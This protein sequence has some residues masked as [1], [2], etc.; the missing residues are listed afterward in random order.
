MR[1]NVTYLFDPLC[2]WCYG[3]SPV[4]GK[5]AQHPDI[6][7]ELAPTGLFADSGQRMDA[8]FAEFAWA[9]DQR[10]ASL[11][12]QRFTE[13]YR[14]NV[15][16]RHGM[17]FDSSAMTRAL[18]AVAQTEPVRELEVLQRLQQA[19]YVEGMDT[20]TAQV[21]D[22]LLRQMG[23]NGIADQV[24][25]NDLALLERNASRLQQ[26]RRLMRSLGAQGV[27]RLVVH[28]DSGMRLLGGNAL[29]G[30]FDQLMELIAVS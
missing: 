24:A 11:S 30:D 3:A 22:V 26:A 17:P 21:V 27:P 20:G 15:L 2:G 23:L 12:G 14:Q 8:S 13:A 5:L 1:T 6:Q 4:I 7:L 25:E 19:R 18:T 16:G 29:Y 28:A 10:I 9:N